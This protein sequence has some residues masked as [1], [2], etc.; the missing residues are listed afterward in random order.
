VVEEVRKI[1]Y[2][3]VTKRF[4]F[5]ENGQVTPGP[6]VVYVIRDGK[7]TEVGPVEEVAGS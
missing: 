3:G 6:I 1:D 7:I 2:E 4:R 5:A